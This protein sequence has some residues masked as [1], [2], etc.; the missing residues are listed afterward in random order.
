MA[1][2]AEGVRIDAAPGPGQENCGENEQKPA[3]KVRRQRIEPGENAHESVIERAHCFSGRRESEGHRQEHGGGAGGESYP[4]F[5]SG[6]SGERVGRGCRGGSVGAGKHGVVAGGANG[7]DERLGGG[8]GGIEDYAGAIG[9]EIDVGGLDSG[10]GAESVFDMML[11][12]S[13][14]HAQHRE[15]ERFR[16]GR[17]HL[18]FQSRGVA[19]LG[20]CGDSKIDGRRI[21]GGAQ[22]GCP[23]THLLDLKPIGRGQSLTDAADTGAAVHVVDTQREFRHWVL[24]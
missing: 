19:G 14:G 10:G 9:D 12:G 15:G 24:R 5:T 17:G 2:G 8:D 6:F 16:C 3:Q 13:A 4:G 11:A 23:K 21:L 18:L 20:Q 22:T 1:E 7:F